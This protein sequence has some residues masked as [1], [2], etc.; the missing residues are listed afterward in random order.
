MSP[1]QWLLTC[2]VLGSDLRVVPAPA[3]A[4]KPQATIQVLTGAAVEGRASVPSSNETFL[5]I[6]IGTGQTLDHSQN[7]ILVWR[8]QCGLFLRYGHV[9]PRWGGV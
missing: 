8:A 1:G 9:H 6:A 3:R 2:I 4:W 7:L 5:V